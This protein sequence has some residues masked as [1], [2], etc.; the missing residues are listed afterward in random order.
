MEQKKNERK[1]HLLK[2]SSSLKM[3]MMAICLFLGSSVFAQSEKVAISGVV[4]DLQGESLI[5]ASVLEKG[6]TNGTIT[7]F[8]GEFTLEVASDA[9]L[10]ISYVGYITREIER[11][12]QTVFRIELTD[13]SKALDEIVVTAL[14]IKREK[15]ALGYSMQEV[16]GDGLTETR[17]NNVANALSGKVAGLQIKQSGTGLTGST[18]IVLRGNNSIQGSNQPLVIVDGIPV[19]NSSGGSDDYWGNRGIDKGSGLSDIS[20]DDIES[21]SVLKGPAAAALYGS[22]AGNGVIMITTKKGISKGLGIS[23]NSNLTFDSPMQTPKFQNIYGQGTQGAFKNDVSGSWG[24]KMTGQSVEDYTTKG[25]NANSSRTSNAYSAQ[26]NDLYKDFLQTGTTW[27]NS[28]DMSAGNENATFRASIMN[29]KNE[30]VIPNSGFDKTSF[31]LR[32]TGKW[33]KLSSDAKITYVHQKVENRVKMAADPDNIFYNYL[34][35]PRNVSFADLQNQDL[36]PNY[37]FPAGSVF[38]G[39]DV[40]GKPASW[41]PNYGGMIRNPYWAAYKNTNLDR[42]NRYLGFFL[43]KYDILPNLYVQARVGLDMGNSHYRMEQATGTPYWEQGGELI[44]TQE[45]FQ[46]MN[47][48]FLIGYNE[49]FGDFGLVVTAGANIMKARSDYMQG[50][51]GGMVIPNFYTLNNGA[52]QRIQNTLTQSQT[53]SLYATAS[54]SYDNFLYLDLTARNDWVSTLNP[55][56][57]S[58]FYPSVGLSFLLTDFLQNRNISTGPLN[59]MKIRTSWAEVGNAVS[60]YQL[61]NYM[62]IR[63]NKVYNPNTGVIEPI[64]AGLKNPV[65][66]LYDLLPESIQSWE[67][68][69]EARAFNN[70]LGLDFTY[71]NKDARNQMLRINLPRGSTYASM[72]VNAGNVNNRG[73]EIVLHGSPVENKNFK[74]DMNLNFSNNKTTIKKLIDETSEQ[75]LGNSNAG[76]ISVRATENGGFGDM[77]G[78]TIMRND[79]GEVMVDDEGLPIINSTFSYLGNY[80][81]DMLIGFNNSLTYKNFY[82]NFLI[83]ARIGGSVYMG[84]IRTGSAFGN[85]ERTLDGRDGMLVEGVLA[86]GTKNTKKVTAENYYARLNNITEPWI[87]DATNIRLREVSFG[88]TLPAVWFNSTPIHS[89]KASFVARNLFMLYSKTEGF[90][91]EGGYAT[92]AAQGIEF[93]SMPTMRSIG[94]N[95]NITF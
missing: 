44:M 84:S 14:G 65:K 16:K 78:T 64:V 80:N 47:S 43:L 90:D 68:G 31:T 8:D 94:F 58:F 29:L 36:F 63:I 33:G 22:R 60:P 30:S 62:D 5:G 7:N 20:P 39:A 92:S 55:N 48:D 21:I 15:K 73:F 54:L 4:T 85:L 77:Y 41:T 57:R 45:S 46:E 12:G 32:S 71:Y 70:R 95:L 10:V 91:P 89:I 18:N 87:Y 72:Y 67:I 17:E 50:T 74:W 52:D 34:T 40:G 93:G 28:L 61:I 6:T 24:A 3:C 2:R 82:F 51:G 13:D 88:Y 83:D 59:F 26:D 81:P 23:F 42:K 76:F 86:D 11:A 75:I 19:D 37:A 35:M 38:E 66:A 69:F 49:N 27:T 1:I 56:N 53:N 9:T 79:A 25:I